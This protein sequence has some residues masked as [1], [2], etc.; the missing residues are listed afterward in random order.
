[1]S[2]DQ[3]LLVLLD[4]FGGTISG[5]LYLEK[6]SF[7]S[8]YEI[9]ELESI[10]ESFSFKPD[11]LGMYSENVL[12]IMDELKEKNLIISKIYVSDT[13]QNKEIFTLT[14]EGRGKAKEILEQI[15]EDVK[16][17]ILNLCKGVKQL[18]YS[19]ILRYTYT[20]YPEFTSESEI[21]EKVFDSYDFKEK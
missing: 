4:C 12:E 10:K 13:Q 16:K 15:D 20:K 1:M 6:L 19:G 2:G 3:L 17:Q 11:K 9:Q 18:G 21:A 5:R 14:P 8:I 7:L